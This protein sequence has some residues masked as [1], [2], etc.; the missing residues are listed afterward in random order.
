MRNV[1]QHQP[2]YRDVP[3]VGETGGRGDVLERRVAGVER[4]RNEG[5]EPAGFVLQRAQARQVVHAVA[6]VLEVAVEHGAIGTQAQLVRR[7]GGFQPL[8]AVDLV[9]ANDAPHPLVENL[10]AASGQRIHPGV[11]QPHQRFADRDLGAPRQVGHLHHGEGLQVDFRKPL[12]EPAQHLAVP[13]QRQLRMQAA[14]D[15]K[16]RDRLA[17]SLAG[18]PPHLFERH[19]VG[20]RVVHAL[21]EGAQAAARHADVR[22]VDMAV[23]VEIRHVAVLALAHQVGHVAHP[24]DVAGTVQR[25]AVLERQP[26]ACLDLRADGNQTGIA[27][28]NLHGQTP[29]L[30]KMMSAAQKTKNSTLT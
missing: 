2:R 21:P 15:V 12:L 30:Q 29:G 25:H 18:V 28:D 5:H 24:Q 16:L 14:H 20:L 1:V 26:L 3:D 6:V 22:G 19:G 13:L 17:P 7:A 11:A 23:D 4:Q 8:V 10:R 27:D 9:V